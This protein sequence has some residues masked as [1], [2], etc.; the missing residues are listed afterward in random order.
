M[1]HS[2][3]P[4]LHPL[5]E[6]ERPLF[7]YRPNQHHHIICDRWHIGELIYPTVLSRQTQM[8]LGI[9]QHIELF[10][11]SRGA[12]MLHITQPSDI[13]YKRIVKRG[14]D[15]IS[16]DQVALTRTLFYDMTKISSLL[17][18]TFMPSTRSGAQATQRTATHINQILSAAHTLERE[19]RDLNSFVTYIGGANPFTL[20]LGDQRGSGTFA[21]SQDQA[22]YHAP[23]FMPY[24]GTSGLYLMHA[25][26]PGLNQL[27]DRIG[28]ANANDVDDVNKLWHTLTYPEIITLG[29]HAHNHL[30][31]LRIPHRQAPHPQWV[32]RF[33]HNRADDYAAY[34]LDNEVIT[35]N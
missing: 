11:Q 22:E 9:F 28:I 6:Y 5:D 24:S 23:A 2:G 27:D 25:L 21:L 18:N 10:L 4:K 17:Y 32:R 7:A 31:D 19:T 20:L 16:P 33:Q 35:W 34:I 12:I 14:D 1:L 15:L 30:L 26:A 3:P 29:Q 13:L 8:D